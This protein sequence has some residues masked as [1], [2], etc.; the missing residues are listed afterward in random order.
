V[1]ERECQKADGV[2]PAVETPEVECLPNKFEVMSSKLQFQQK[3]KK[4][5]KKWQK[6]SQRV[7]VCSRKQSSED[8]QGL[9]KYRDG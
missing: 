8:R 4:K 1:A 2:A 7:V 3:K 5:K 9:W 6:E